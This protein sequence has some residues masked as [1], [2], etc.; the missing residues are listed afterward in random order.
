MNSKKMGPLLLL[1]AFFTLVL[2]PYLVLSTSLV[3]RSTDLSI[4][5]S[6]DHAGSLEPRPEY[7]IL[8]MAILLI[9]VI[10]RYFYG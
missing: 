1:I 3:F 6:F 10:T 7:C 8:R 5:W 4:N 9:I 2:A